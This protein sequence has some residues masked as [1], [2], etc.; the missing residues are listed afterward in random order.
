MNYQEIYWQKLSTGQMCLQY[1]P[2]CQKYIFYPRESCPHCLQPGLE[3]KS[4]SG[5]GRVYS[6]AI[7]NVTALP[8][9]KDKV[10]Y[11]YAVIELA[12]GVRLPSNIIGCPL[13]KIQ[14]G[15]PVQIAFIV[16]DGCTLPVFAPA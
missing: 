16:S 6:Y 1:C 3:W 9:F 13:D 11:I 12:E 2:E 4:I 10:P 15:M 5:Q 14:V 8:E 7:V